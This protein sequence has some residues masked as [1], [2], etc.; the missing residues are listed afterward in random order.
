MPM[1]ISFMEN[2]PLSFTIGATNSE[3]DPFETLPMQGG[4]NEIV[5]CNPG[6]SFGGSWSEGINAPCPSS[7]ETLVDADNG[8]I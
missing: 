7:G 6:F 4:Q 1:Q 5:D 2:F 3:F 8:R